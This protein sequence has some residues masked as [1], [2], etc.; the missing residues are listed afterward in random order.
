MMH[1]ITLVIPDEVYQPLLRKAQETG[2]PLEAVANACLA[3]ALNPKPGWGRLRRWAGAFASGVPD[4]GLRH[5]E[6]L[7]HALLEEL[8]GKPDA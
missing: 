4:A 2:Q 7:G 1:Q 3:H 5:D 6:Y 8:R